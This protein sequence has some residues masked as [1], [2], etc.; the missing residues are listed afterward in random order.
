MKVADIFKHHAENLVKHN[1]FKQLMPPTVREYW[2]ELLDKTNSRQLFSWV[3]DF[4]QPA[5]EDVPVVEPIVLKPEAQAV[6]NQLESKLGEVIHT[7][8]WLLVD[9]NR[10]NQFGAITED[11][12]WIHTDPE[13]AEA[14]SPFKTTIAH[15][16][17]TLA[18]LPKLTDSVDEDK[19][20]FPTAKMMVNI[21]LNSV[22]FPYPIKVDSRV[23]AVSTLSKV[24][25]IK[26]GLEIEREIKVEIE[27]VRRP[28]CVVTSVIQLHF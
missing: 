10:I 1:E 11:M 19:L 4:H 7:G 17:L 12:Q 15:G 26:K 25:P 9:Q 2:G 6:Y 16:F 18:L 27:G 20:L 8:D 14:E 5:N 3:K 22:R 24:T 28:G 13:R 21:G 23:R